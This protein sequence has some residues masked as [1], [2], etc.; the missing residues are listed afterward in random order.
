MRSLDVP[1][2][3]VRGAESTFVAPEAF[4]ATRSLRPDLPAS[5]VSGADHY[6]PEEQP[7]L[8]A[9]LIENFL[10]DA[11]SSRPTVLNYLGK[12]SGNG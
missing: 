3:F 10:A 4:E 2:L 5:V 9:D 12:R 7:E 6:V 1:A 8:L 11:G